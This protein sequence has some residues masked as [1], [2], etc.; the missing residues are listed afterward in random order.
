MFFLTGDVCGTVCMSCSQIGLITQ[1]CSNP[2]AVQSF[3]PTPL[4]L[5]AAI[6]VLI[7][8]GLHLAAI[9]IKEAFALLMHSSVYS[10]PFIRITE[11]WLYKYACN[12]TVLP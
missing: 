2:N 10:N 6:V 5:E 4:L 11:V 1:S 12:L 9:S 3:D 8:V 7:N